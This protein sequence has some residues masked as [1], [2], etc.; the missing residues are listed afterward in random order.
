MLHGVSNAGLFECFGEDQLVAFGI[1]YSKIAYAPGMAHR[2]TLNVRAFGTKVRVEGVGVVNVELGPADSFVTGA[3]IAGFFSVIHFSYWARH[4]Y[5]AT[6]FH[7]VPFQPFFVLP[8][9]DS[10]C[11]SLF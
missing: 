2:L 11:L 9:L 1:E 7:R 3:T 4:L 8:F 5:R 10:L 6:V